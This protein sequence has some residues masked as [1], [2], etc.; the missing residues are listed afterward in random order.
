M[1]D[2]RDQYSSWER[3][4]DEFVN[5]DQIHP[6]AHLTEKVTNMV[7]HDLKPDIWN[8]FTKLAGVQAAC[9][10]VT[11]LFC[12]QFE[13]GF[14]KHDPFAGLIHSVGEFGLLVVCGII[15]LGSGAAIAPLFLK[16]SDMKAI[17]RSMLAYFPSAAL[18]AVIL[19]YLFGANINLTLAL[20]WFLGGSLG[21][22]IGFALVKNIRHTL[23][24]SH[25]Y[26]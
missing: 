17:S 23:I 10:A 22:I 6:P 5:S 7:S 15:F 2:K 3:D 16:Q 4:F 11:L 13:V 25:R 14:A 9:A 18:L 19:F 26:S 12:P 24:L 8:I 21:G 20:P 1:R